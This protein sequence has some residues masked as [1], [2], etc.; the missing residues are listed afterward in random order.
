MREQTIVWRNDFENITPSPTK[1]I[2]E[3]IYG[4]FDIGHFID[5]FLYTGRNEV[6]FSTGEGAYALKEL[7]SFAFL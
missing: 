6:V 3:T 5:S 2:A 4:S 1:V 7:E